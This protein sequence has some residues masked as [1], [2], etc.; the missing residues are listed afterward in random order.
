MPAP[1]VTSNPAEF[2]RLEGVYIDEKNPPGFV[3]GVFLNRVGVFGTTVR[4]PVDTPVD[5]TSYGR[6]LEVFG[7]RDRGS[8]GAI[9]SEVW[10]SLLGKEWGSITVVR[11]AAAAAVAA[12]FTAETAAGGGGTAVL[13]VDASSAGAWGNDV[14]FKVSAATDLDA[15]H[16]NLTVRYLGK[17]TTYEN[18]DISGSNDNTLATVGDDYANV[19]TL[20]KLASGRPV[21]H[22]AGVDGA[23]SS[24]FVNLGETVAAFTS[25]LGADGT[26]AASDYT[27]AG[28]GLNKLTF[29]PGLG[30]VY[31]A[32]EDGTITAAV[33][34]A[35][36]TATASIF[37]R[38]FCIHEGALTGAPVAVSTV[39]TDAAS[40]RRDR[41]IYCH[42]AA[43]FT[44]TETA[45][46]VLC[47]PN[48][49]M[50]NILSKIDVDVHPGEEAT[51]RFTGGVKG[52]NDEGLTRED[53]ITLREAGVCSLEKDSEG[54]FVFVSGVTTDLTPGKTEITRRRSADF[55]QLSVADR[56]KFYVKKKSSLPLRAAMAAEVSAFLR[57]LQRQ[58]RV[59]EEFEVSNTT[60]SAE[61]S[62]GLELLLMRVKLIGHMLHIVLQTEIGTGVTI[63]K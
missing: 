9:A 23:D 60:S 24:G 43:K 2:T 3:K 14:Q 13:R 6:F 27:A 31:C 42:N 44:D 46:M 56:L 30:V 53:Y 1:I 45:T 62:Q 7:G 29:Y 38:V 55:L 40:F 57:G 35:I 63:E 34:A 10:K 48:S 61:R 11:V 18:L 21:N 41:I 4:G 37:D 8:G 12:S 58:L 51:K 19:V 26:P 33:N 15:N 39:A 20:T 16:F 59:V 22:S 54:G 50:A 5:V 36:M 52:L 32:N 25:V 47:A 17:D 28:R 49:V